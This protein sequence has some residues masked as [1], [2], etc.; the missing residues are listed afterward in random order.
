MSSPTNHRTPIRSP[1]IKQLLQSLMHRQSQD[2]LQNSDNTQYVS[3]TVP[4]VTPK[5]NDC[6]AVGRSPSNYE[7]CPHYG[8]PPGLP[9]PPAY[10]QLATGTSAQAVISRANAEVDA[11]VGEAQGRLLA[12]NLVGDP[13]GSATPDPTAPHLLGVTPGQ[14]T[15]VNTAPAHAKVGSK[16]RRK[17]SA[18]EKNNPNRLK[19]PAPPIVVSDDSAEELASFFAANTDSLLGS[20]YDSVQN[21]KSKPKAPV[22]P[23][24]NRLQEPPHISSKTNRHMFVDLEAV[25]DDPK[26]GADSDNSMGDMD[27]DHYDLDDPFIDDSTNSG[28]KE[29]SL[30][31]RSRREDVATIPLSR[32]STPDIY[33]SD[34]SGFDSAEDPWLAAYFKRF[35]ARRRKMKLRQERT[36]LDADVAVANEPTHN[37]KK[38]KGKARARVMSDNDED[39]LLP[40]EHFPI[41]PGYESMSKNERKAILVAVEASRRTQVTDGRVGESSMQGG[42]SASSPSNR[43]APSAVNN[44]TP[45][46]PSP[47]TTGFPITPSTGGSGTAAASI[48]H[49]TPSQNGTATVASPSPATAHPHTTRR[50]TALPDKCLINDPV[51]QDS[52]LAGDY[53]GLP[54]LRPG[55]LIPWSDMPGPGQVFFMAWGDQ[56]PHMNGQS[57]Y[58]AL[59]FVNEGNFTNP[60]RSSPTDTEV[61]E[62]PGGRFHLYRN[63]HPLVAVSP[64]FLEQSQLLTPSTSGLTQKFVRGIMHSQ[65]WERFVGWT[66]M[67]FGH[68]ALAAQLAKDAL[69]FSTRP[70]FDSKD[71]S[72]RKSNVM[73]KNTRSPS[74][75]SS[76]TPNRITADTFALPTD[77]AVPVYDARNANFNFLQDLPNLESLPRWEAEIPYGSSVVVGYTLAVYRAKGGNWTLGCNI[78]WAVIVGLPADEA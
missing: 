50:C 16:T 69:Q 68:E 20:T 17:T 62:V 75:R 4:F 15:G 46:T 41:E 72:K 33:A 45:Q 21:I 60:S 23:N 71:D 10:R 74:T 5:L 8:P 48:S 7:V 22:T 18:K 13:V 11:G 2:A 27:L 19:E 40:D 24:G 78:Q 73:F 30:G 29:K 26:S 38:N 47:F 53:N 34:F 56:C 44:T 39:N 31:V 76:R 6:D 12:S 57:A 70:R 49:T 42:S 55:Q 3:V 77:G 43:V 59:S 1:S 9:H 14:P 36:N 54:P 25:E 61:R 64:I 28:T 32:G 51:L 66:C 37:R 58:S 67:A 63:G 35:I 65:E 52:V